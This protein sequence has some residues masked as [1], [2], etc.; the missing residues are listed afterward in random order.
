MAQYDI[1]LSTKYNAIRL[2]VRNVLESGSG[3][4]GYGGSTSSSD[5]YFGKRIEELDF[6]YLR[7]DINLCYKHQNGQ[8]SALTNIGYQ[9]IISWADFLAYDLAADGIASNRDA[10]YTGGT[11]GGLT[12]QVTVT[13]GGSATLTSGWGNNAA[14][15][16]YGQQIYNVTWANADAARYFFN[17]GGYLRFTLSRSGTS[18]N[19]K[20]TGWQTVVDDMA[21]TAFTFSATQYRQGVAGSATA[22]D[23]Q[24]FDATNP[25]TENY[26]YMRYRWINAYTIE[27]LLQMVD[28][29]TGDKTGD[30][31]AVDETVTIDITGGMQYRRSS[32]TISHS[33][34]T[35]SVAAWTINV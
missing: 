3:N 4:T 19:T 21:A 34:P 18:T 6:D 26:G 12:Q 13:S 30:G 1:I 16:R 24:K 28:S 22:W 25:Y 15:K 29:D 10:V 20:S 2:K 7:N 9:G 33:A 35:V 14:S 5:V 8:D 11:G 31:P 23:Y 17:A 27:M 32:G